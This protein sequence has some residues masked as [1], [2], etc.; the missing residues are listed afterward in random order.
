M[1]S[2][3]IGELAGEVSE[4]ISEYTEDVRVAI[5]EE[6]KKSAHDLVREI[7]STTAFSDDPRHK[8]HLRNSFV[9]TATINEHDFKEYEIH[10]KN[11]KYRIVHLVENGHALS[12]TSRGLYGSVPAHHFLAP[13]SE[14]YKEI[15]GRHVEEIIKKGK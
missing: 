12:N 7:P 2:I 9:A 6:V 8:T 4:L 15:I 14:K 11:G 13:L 5:A 3:T 1:P 10:A